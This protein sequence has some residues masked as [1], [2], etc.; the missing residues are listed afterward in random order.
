MWKAALLNN[1][2]SGLHID[3]LFCF[4]IDYKDFDCFLEVCYYWNCFVCY[5]KRVGSIPFGTIF[6]NCSLL[7]LAI[8]YTL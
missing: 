3:V 4:E 7:I 5:L 6:S 2:E 1:L 8:D